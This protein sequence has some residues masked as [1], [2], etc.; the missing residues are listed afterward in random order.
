MFKRTAIA[1][2]LAGA[3]TTAPAF[4]AGDRMSDTWKEASISTAY[5]LNEH[6]NPFDV[7]V[8]VNGGTARLTGTVESSVEKDLAEQIAL[9][10]DG[11]KQVDNNLS[12]ASDT[13]RRDNAGDFSQSVS[14]AGITAKVKSKLLWNRSTSGLKVNVTTQQRKVTLEGTVESKAERDLVRRIALNTDGVRAID[15][16]LTVKPDMD[17]EKNPS[18]VEAVSELKDKALDAWISTKVKS[19][20]LYSNAVDGTGIDV[21]T[22]AGVVTLTG[23]VWDERARDQAVFIT[24]GIIGVQKVRTN[25]QVNSSSS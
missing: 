7:D 11:V 25:L 22:T 4:A 17:P 13:P 3:L 24:E 16:K 21:D 20:L 10:V 1:V 12:V 2:A 23:R 15:D 8:E 9:S 19:A 6:L 18:P 14:D 5:T